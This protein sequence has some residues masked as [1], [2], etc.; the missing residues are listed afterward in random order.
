MVAW[1]SLLLV[2]FVWNFRWWKGGLFYLRK[3][4]FGE[5]SYWKWFILSLKVG[6]LGS[7]AIESCLL[8]LWKLVFWEVWQ[9]KMVCSIFKIIVLKEYG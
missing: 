5:F 2:L 3:L 8:C 6:I 4:V 1:I 7:L 9:E